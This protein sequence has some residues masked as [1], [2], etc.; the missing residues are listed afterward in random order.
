M[1]LFGAQLLLWT[2]IG[3]FYKSGSWVYVI[4]DDRIPCHRGGGSGPV[5]ARCRD[6]EELW[7]PILEK[8]YAKCH[9]SYKVVSTSLNLTL[10]NRKKKQNKGPAWA[11]GC[12]ACSRGS[13]AVDHFD[14]LLAT[15]GPARAGAA[16]FFF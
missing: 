3:R 12:L 2:T 4:V 9:G 7:V 8:A 6:P 1:S 16:S 5:F 15:V 14:V 11:C 10:R 13:R